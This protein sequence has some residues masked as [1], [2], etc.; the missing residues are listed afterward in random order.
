MSMHIFCCISSW[1]AGVVWQLEAVSWFDVMVI[2]GF[3][4][5]RNF[6][7]VFSYDHEHD[8]IEDATSE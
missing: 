5:L 8:V 2:F 1:K 6:I 4:L 3:M 7:F